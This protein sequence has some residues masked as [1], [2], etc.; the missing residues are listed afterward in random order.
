MKA[1]K[2]LIF[3]MF[4]LIFSGCDGTNPLFPEDDEDASLV[5][6]WQMI[7]M[8]ETDANGNLI[9]SDDNPM[10][11][12]MDI[13]AKI[14]ENDPNTSTYDLD[15][16]GSI[17]AITMAMFAEITSSYVRLHVKVTVTDPGDPLGNVFDASQMGLDSFTNYTKHNTTEDKTYTTLGNVI[18]GFGEDNETVTYSISGTKLTIVAVDNKGTLTDT[19][20]DKTN[21]MV[22]SQASSSDIESSVHDANLSISGD[23]D[24]N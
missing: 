22:F 1:N 16:D 2:V 7:S 9:T 12:P 3:L 23:D 20:D 24:N 6:V 13:G 17:E 4:I 14:I 21:T 8:T 5:N 18:N 15:G 10:I 11:F 19:S